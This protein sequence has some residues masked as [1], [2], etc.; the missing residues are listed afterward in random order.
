MIVQK[1]IIIN[2]KP[3]GFNLITNKVL[4]ALPEMNNFS[5]GVLHLFIKHTSASLSISENADPTVRIDLE[6][7]FNRSV[8]EDIALYR[9]TIEGLDDMT[10]HIK[11]VIIG[12]SLSL[13]IANGRL[14]LGTWQGIYL[15]EHRNYA[16]N[17]TIVATI[18][19][20]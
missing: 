11:N 12:S 19:G 18:W 2:S 1:E 8:P 4:D 6:T 14:E 10:S 20:E 17:R 15:C 5:A 7:Y 9:H 13:P 16:K 3:R